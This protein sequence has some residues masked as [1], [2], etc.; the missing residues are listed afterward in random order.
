MTYCGNLSVETGHSGLSALETAAVLLIRRFLSLDISRQ[1]LV[2][3]CRK[4]EEDFLGNACGPLDFFTG[5]FAANHALLLSDFAA[6]HSQPA[7]PRIAFR[8]S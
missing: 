2:K 8:F 7:V 6:F 4:V 3:L 5:L 1:E